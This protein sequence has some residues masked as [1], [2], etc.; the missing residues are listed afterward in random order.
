MSSGSDITAD[1]GEGYASKDGARQAVKNVKED[2]P[3]AD[4][5]E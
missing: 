4:T 3:G 2:A 1:S 5:E